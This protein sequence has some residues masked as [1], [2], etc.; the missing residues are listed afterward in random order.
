MTFQRARRP[1]HK[2]QRAEAILAAARSLAEKDGVRS[3]S[4]AD[5]ASAVG[6]HKSALLRYFETR[7]EI[8]LRLAADDWLDWTTAM[9]A[10]LGELA[11]G[12]VSGVAAALATTLAERPLLCDLMT[13]A[14]LNLERNVSLETARTFKRAA[15]GS[16][17][18]IATEVRTVLP[19]LTPEGAFDLVGAVDMVAAGLWQIGHPPPTLVELYAEEPRLGHAHLP[20]VP[21]VTRL[22]ETL[23][24]GLLATSR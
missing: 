12:D 20:F 7:E 8:Y 17:E 4:L 5:I 19:A 16:V 13:H 2:R 6:M 15:V 18:A 24:H 11:E 14:A 10:A 21:T 3:V 22:A 23:I 1:E 9:R